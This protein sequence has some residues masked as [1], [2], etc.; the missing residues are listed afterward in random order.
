MLPGEKFDSQ[1]S[2]VFKLILLPTPCYYG[3][4]V[5]SDC[6]DG[7]DEFLRKCVKFQPSCFSFELAYDLQLI[8]FLFS[9]G[10]GAGLE[11]QLSGGVGVMLWIHRCPP[12]FTVYSFILP[13]VDILLVLST[14]VL[15]FSI[16]NSSF[17]SLRQWDL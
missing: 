9:S 1:P 10:R 13:V 3:L 17:L 11:W 12:K 16:G 7:G 2:F 15:P 6:A 8:H 4:D 14:T 5:M